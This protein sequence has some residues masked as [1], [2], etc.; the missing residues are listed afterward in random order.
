M[1]VMQHFNL[2]LVLLLLLAGGSCLADSSHSEQTDQPAAASENGAKNGANAVDKSQN[3]RGAPAIPVIIGTPAHQQQQ[4]T[5]YINQ[6]HVAGATVVAAPISGHATHATALSAVPFGAYGH[7]TVAGTGH[8]LQ[9][10]SVAATPQYNYA[11]VPQLTYTH[12]PQYQLYHQQQHHHPQQQQ[13]QS[14]GL[15]HEY[16][17]PI[18]ATIHE[19]AQQQQQTAYAHQQPIYA[20]HPATAIHYAVP[21]TL[22]SG[23]HNYHGQQQHQHQQQQQQQYPLTHTQAIHYQQAVAGGG[24]PSV[25]IVHQAPIATI[26]Q[27]HQAQQIYAA[28]GQLTKYP[29]SG[30]SL[31]YGAG[32]L[33]QQQ[34]QQ[35]QHH[36]NQI[37]STAPSYGDPDTLTNLALPDPT[38]P[39][40]RPFSLGRR[41]VT[42]PTPTRP[43]PADVRPITE[44]ED[45]VD[46]DDGNGNDDLYR[47]EQQ[48]PTGSTQPYDDR[49]TDLSFDPEEPCDKDAKRPGSAFNRNLYNMWRAYSVARTLLQAS[50]SAGSGTSKG[51][52]KPAK[53]NTD[54]IQLIH[55]PGESDKTLKGKYY[56]GKY[57]EYNRQSRQDGL[58]EDAEK[59]EQ[60]QSRRRPTEGNRRPK[61]ATTAAAAAVASPKSLP[62]F[63]LFWSELRNVDRRCFAQPFT[64]F[65]HHPCRCESRSVMYELICMF[66]D[67]STGFQHQQQQQHRPAGSSPVGGQILPTIATPTHL[68]LKPLL[69]VTTAST[70]Q[71][72]SNGISYSTFTHPGLAQL[73]PVSPQGVLQTQP[74]YYN[75]AAFNS[76]QQQ[77]QQQQQ[78][79]TYLR[80]PIQLQQQQQQQQQQRVPVYSTVATPLQKSGQFSHPVPQYPA[81]AFGQQSTAAGLISGGPLY[82]HHQQQQPS[83]ASSA[84][85]TY[86]N[87]PTVNIG[88]TVGAGGGRGSI[89]LLH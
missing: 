79:T 78:S 34:Q 20:H 9:A 17:H 70:T 62:T 26:N 64:L 21:A 83:A 53:G 68:Q 7:H 25:P 45:D 27:V 12:Y 75:A 85:L 13:Q 49:R 74:V 47:D 80:T 56:R 87:V 8:I 28:Q 57:Y 14:T 55:P 81:Y 38:V 73:R 23:Q 18:A 54:R 11:A 16:A 77:Q 58:V 33:Q 35:Q 40:T 51:K 4:H 66:S 88:G 44:Y 48:P 19:L 43:F 89:Y 59:E 10:A 32:G 86:A 41:P 3:K 24:Q 61:S 1:K 37:Y 84:R 42:R 67:S 29:V 22:V 65:I 46:G 76:Q 69:P 63:P 82:H 52:D 5:A 50:G 31:V 72:H 15:T 6:H 30:Q 39:S 2:V 71:H 60:K 36:P